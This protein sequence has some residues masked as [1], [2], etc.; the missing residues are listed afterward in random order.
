MA[1]LLI[2]ESELKQLDSIVGEIPMKYG[3]ALVNF[4]NGVGQLRAKEAQE[5]QQAI[6]P[7][8]QP[9]GAGEVAP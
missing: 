5:S 3:I 4:I 8:T 2:K 9:A 6:V 1:D 7:K